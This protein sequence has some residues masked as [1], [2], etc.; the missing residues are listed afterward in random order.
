MG[1][2]WDPVGQTGRNM[3]TFFLNLSEGFH[4]FSKFQLVFPF[5]RMSNGRQIWICLRGVGLFTGAAQLRKFPDLIFPK[6]RTSNRM[7][8]LICRQLVA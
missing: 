5:F 4:P 7:S 8:I 1:C 2:L 6:P 3:L